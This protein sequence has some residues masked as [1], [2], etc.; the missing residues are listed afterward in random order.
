VTAARGA[1]E[2]RPRAVGTVLAVAYVAM[3]RGVTVLEQGLRDLIAR[4]AVAWPFW[5]IIVVQLVLGVATFAVVVGAPRFPWTPTLVAVLLAYG[6]AESSVSGVA[7]LLPTLGSWQPRLDWG[8]ATV[9]L[10]TGVMLA[11]AVW[12]W[13]V[14]REQPA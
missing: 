1:D 13:W 9:S 4:D 7:H 12:G 14:G 2:W 8:I 3:L 6:V 5:A 11:T 10:L